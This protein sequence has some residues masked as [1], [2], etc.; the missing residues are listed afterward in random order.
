[1]LDRD[2]DS[3]IS[4]SLGC[5]LIGPADQI[6]CR[7]ALLSFF[8]KNDYVQDN[9]YIA[10]AEPLAD[11]L[12]RMVD[13]VVKVGLIRESPAS[14]DL[15]DTALMGALTPPPSVVIERFNRLYAESPALATD[16]FYRFNQDCN[17]IRRD[18][19]DKDLRWQTPTEY[20][21]LD[22]T[23]NLSKPEKDPRDIAAARQKHSGGYPACV[24]CAENEGYAGRIDHPARQNLRIIPVDML[25]EAWGF[26]YSPYVYYNEHCIVLN[27]RHVPMVID[28]TVFAKLFAF[29]SRFPDY[30]VGSNADLPIVGGSILAHEHFQGGRHDFPM[31]KAP[32]ERHF[33][34]AGQSDVE[35]G[36]VHWPMSVIRLRHADPE[37]LSRLAAEILH[38]WR[39]YCDESAFII[40]ET[41]GVPHNTITPIARQRGGIYELDLVLRNNITTAEHPFG[42]Y[43]PHI[44]LHNIKKEN[45]GL[46]EVMGLAVLPGRLV[47]EMDAVKAAILTGQD[48]HELPVVRKH[49]KWVDSWLPKYASLNEQTIEEIFRTEIGLTFATVLEHA[50]VF[51]RTA[52]GQDAFARFLESFDY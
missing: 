39:N 16:F 18:R 38:Q 19:S 1:M 17:Y 30:F 7:N 33:T 41:D 23:I 22:I 31:A 20:G 25:G 8:N 10:A 44:E 26:Q 21:N 27:T 36:I 9:S 12:T 13:S 3:L 28:E 11:I 5:G 43:H 6:F 14:R 50:G 52:K 37:K 24:L 47:A 49:A 46:I 4:Y 15:F 45:I 2:I 32:I 40:A 51:A 29:V 34:I 48:L 42:V 35:A